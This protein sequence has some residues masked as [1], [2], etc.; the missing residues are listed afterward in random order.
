MHTICY[1]EGSSEE[2]QTAR[3]FLT[4]DKNVEE[5]STF[6]SGMPHFLQKQVC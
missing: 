3:V 4:E 6:R 1:G 2:E 5:L